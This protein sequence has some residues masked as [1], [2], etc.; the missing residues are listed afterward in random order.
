MIDGDNYEIVNTA[1]GE[2]KKLTM[3]DME[4]IQHALLKMK[5]DGADNT[6]QFI[7]VK[8]EIEYDFYYKGNTLPIM[9][10][11]P[12]QQK[13]KGYMA[14][15]T[16]IDFAKSVLSPMPGA[17]VSVAVGVGDAVSDGQEIMVIEAMKMQNVLKAEV[18]GKVKAIHCKAG[19]AVAVDELLLEFE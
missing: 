1:T 19:D 5:I 2:N 3:T 14:P 17:I 9:V 13:Y 7:N 4:F 11:D 16:K 15:P 10:H 8:D 18:D 12:N 6:L